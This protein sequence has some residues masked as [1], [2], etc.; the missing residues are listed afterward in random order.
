M[1]GLSVETDPVLMIYGLSVDRHSFNAIA[2]YC[3]HEEYD[4]DISAE[5]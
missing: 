5:V 2:S 3:D 4:A 1:Y